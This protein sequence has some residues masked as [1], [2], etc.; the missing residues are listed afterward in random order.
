M[1]ERVLRDDE[2][3][4]IER[5]GER[6]GVTERERTIFIIFIGPR[7]NFLFFFCLALNYSAHLSID[8]HC[9]NEAKKNKYSSTA[10]C[11][12]LVFWWT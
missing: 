8:V 5:E 4:S 10:T 2:S 7:V 9:S 11:F 6:H 12:F 3:F 1:P